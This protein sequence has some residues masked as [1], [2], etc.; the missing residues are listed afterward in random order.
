MD[1]LRKKLQHLRP[2]DMEAINS[3]MGSLVNKIATSH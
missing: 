3:A 2:E 1:R